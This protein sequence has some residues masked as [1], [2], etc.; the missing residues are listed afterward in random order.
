[1]ESRYCLV[2]WV[3]ISAPGVTTIHVACARF[4]YGGDVIFNEASNIAGM[5]SREQILS[6]ADTTTPINVLE[7]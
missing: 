4:A 2:A 6:V 3:A 5:S 7:S 1:M